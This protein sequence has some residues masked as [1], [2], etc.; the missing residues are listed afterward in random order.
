MLLSLV[1]LLQSCNLFSD[2]TIE[3]TDITKVA[4]R[5]MRQTISKLGNHIKIEEREQMPVEIREIVSGIEVT[6]IG[7]R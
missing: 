7:D 6:K 5:K 3:L 1:N 2:R 4:R